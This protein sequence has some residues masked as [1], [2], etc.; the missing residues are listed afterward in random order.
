VSRLSGDTWIRYRID[1]ASAPPVPLEGVLTPV[2]EAIIAALRKH[3]DHEQNQLRSGLRFWEHGLT[4]A[5]V[6]LDEEGPLCIQWLLTD[7][8]NDR[9]RQL[10]TWGGMYPPIP[11]GYGRVE[12]LFTFSTARRKGIASQFEFMLYEEAKRLGL[13]TLLTHIHASNTAANG[14]AERTGWR[15]YGTIRRYTVDAPGF[16]GRAIYV[17]RV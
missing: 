9:V 15:A 10:P 8:D 1:L 12:N 17:H 6:W 3:P 11:R 5:F 4:R 2:T 14:W 13:S 7:R 16:R